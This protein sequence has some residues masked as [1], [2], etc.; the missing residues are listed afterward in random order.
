M[1]RRLFLQ[2]L[3]FVAF[4]QD[5][6]VRQRDPENLEFPFTSLDSYVT[7]NDRFYIRSHFKTPEL[8]LA[9]Y[10]LRV[11]GAV[12]KPF[13]ITLDEIKRLAQR[14]VTAT[15]ECAGNTRALLNPPASGV[16]WELGAVS[17]AEWSGVPLGALLEKAGLKSNAVEVVLEG[18]DKGEPK[19]DPK[20]VGEIAFARSISIEKARRPEVLLAHGMNGSD[21]ALSHGAPLRTVVPGYYGMS[22]IK[23]LTKVR[24]VTE[25]FQ[26]YFQTIDYAY[27]DRTNGY[28]LRQPLLDMRVKSLIAQPAKNQQIKAGSTV[29]LRGAAWTGEADISKVEISSDGGK[30]WGQARFLDKANR[31]AWRRWEFDWKAPSQPGRQFLM[32]RATDS[33]GA[34]QALQHDRDTAGYVIHHVIPVEIN[35]L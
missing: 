19:N 20:P 34:V 28:P 17:N 11:E 10:K 18:A 35:V 1:N 25:R 2:T 22:S 24:V 27:W 8:D 6:I 23:W 13:E 7:P 12:E 9:S 32:S 33:K 29:T 30:T 4:G 3:P 31:F 14:K 21:L 26:G 15:L 16:Q 5:L